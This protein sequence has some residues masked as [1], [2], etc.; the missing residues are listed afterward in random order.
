MEISF[1]PVCPA[2]G[3]EVKNIDWSQPL[4]QPSAEAIIEAFHEHILLLFRDQVAG[5]RPVN[6]G[7]P[8][9][10]ARPNGFPQRRAQAAV[11]LYRGGQRT[12]VRLRNRV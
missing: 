7:Q 4:D 8:R 3:V 11:A 1:Q 10:H 2:I 5:R 6:V 12:H 9:V